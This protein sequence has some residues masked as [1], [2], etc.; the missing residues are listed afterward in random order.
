MLKAP[1]LLFGF[2]DLRVVQNNTLTSV[3]RIMP[4]N[5]LPVHF[6]GAR[7]E[8]GVELGAILGHFPRAFE[9]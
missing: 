5:R 1:H 9:A 7:L 4:I 8:D 2:N 3:G 6:L